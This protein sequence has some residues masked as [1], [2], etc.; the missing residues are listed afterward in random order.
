MADAGSALT[1][2][3]RRR[4]AK[5]RAAAEARPAGPGSSRTSPSHICSQSGESPISLVVNTQHR[6]ADQPLGPHRC[7]P[8]QRGG[9]RGKSRRLPPLLNRGRAAGRLGTSGSLSCRAFLMGCALVGYLL[10][11]SLPPSPPLCTQTNVPGSLRCSKCCTA[12]PLRVGTKPTPRP[13]RRHRLQQR[14][15]CCCPRRGRPAPGP[16]PQAS[17]SKARR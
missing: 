3:I 4:A 14:R 10:P 16:A 13:R 6:A 7:P 15:R 12:G 1:G 2:W 11:P 9:L 17:C 5:A 8:P